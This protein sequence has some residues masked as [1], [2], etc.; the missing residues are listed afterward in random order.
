MGRMFY[1]CSSLKYIDLSSFNTKSVEGFYEMFYDCDS[2]ESLDLS[3]FKF[4]CV[5]FID[6]MFSGC[7]NLKYLNVRGW[8]ISK[9][10]RTSGE[11]INSVFSGCTSLTSL[12]LTGWNPISAKRTYGLFRDCESLTEIIMPDFTTPLVDTFNLMF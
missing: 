12:D 9:A 11:G 4:D 8:D 1:R 3:H 2:L 6:D 10:G 7:T 5:D